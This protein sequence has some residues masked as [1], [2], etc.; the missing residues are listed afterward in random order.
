MEYPQYRELKGFNRYYKIIDDRNFTEVYFIGEK[1]VSHHIEAKQY[2]EM[3]RIQ[4]MLKCESPF[5]EI[6]ENIYLNTVKN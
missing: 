1:V 6:S 2:P 5:V 3:L 4:D